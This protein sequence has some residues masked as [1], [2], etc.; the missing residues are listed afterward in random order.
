[1]AG[2]STPA[3]N[4]RMINGLGS[5]QSRDVEMAGPSGLDRAEKLKQRLYSYAP[6]QVASNPYALR[7]KGVTQSQAKRISV[8]LGPKIEPLV[9]ITTAWFNFLI[10][11]HVKLSAVGLV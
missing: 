6:M 4:G 7:F 1:M 5:S 2:S 10:L 9:C 11:I 3:M 8:P